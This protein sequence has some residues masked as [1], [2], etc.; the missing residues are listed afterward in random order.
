MFV[1]CSKNKKAATEQSPEQLFFCFIYIFQF[2]TWILINLKH[3]EHLFTVLFYTYAYTFLRVRFFRFPSLKPKKKRKKENDE[4]CK[5]TCL[6][7]SSTAN[8]FLLDNALQFKYKINRKKKYK[9]T[10]KRV[11]NNSIHAHNRHHLHEEKLNYAIHHYRQS[12]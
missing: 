1:A 2:L 9:N 10:E 12:F 8:L 6:H 3:Y 7:S 5:V 4:I 11:R